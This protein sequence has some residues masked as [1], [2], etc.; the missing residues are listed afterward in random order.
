[1]Q[2]TKRVE[3]TFEM[4]SALS[5][6]RFRVEPLCSAWWNGLATHNVDQNVSCAYARIRKMVFQ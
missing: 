6:V 3:E 5:L 2:G 1:M 4:S